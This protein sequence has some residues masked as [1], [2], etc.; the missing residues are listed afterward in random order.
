MN[1]KIVNIVI[2][3][4]VKTKN[5]ITKKNV[6][7]EI[8]MVTVVTVYVKNAKLIITIAC[9]FLIELKNVVNFFGGDFNEF[10]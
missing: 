1:V 6:S 5:V 8:V 2:L 3:K 4:N 10:V 9:V 7:I